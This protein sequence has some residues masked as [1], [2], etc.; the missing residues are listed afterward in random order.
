MSAFDLIVA[1]LKCWRCGSISPEDQTT[2]MQSRLSA[3]PDGRVYQ[4]GD[5]IEICREPLEY[6]TYYCIR[7]PVFPDDILVAEVWE[8][9]ACAY[10]PCWALVKI[11][12]RSSAIVS[13]DSIKLTHDVFLSLNFITDECLNCLKGPIEDDRVLLRF[14]ELVR[15]GR[16]L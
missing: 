15:E 16:F 8:C 13:V 11:D 9:P 3:S 4:V 10:A 12:F 1:R 14:S 5:R 2:N 7:L 6:F